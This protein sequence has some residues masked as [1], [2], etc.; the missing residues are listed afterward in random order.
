[1]DTDYTRWLGRLHD[2]AAGDRTIFCLP[3]GGGGTST[4]HGWRRA[5]PGWLDVAPVRLPGREQRLAEPAGFRPADIAAAIAA[6]ADCPYAIFGHS[7]GALVGFEVIRELRRLGAPYPLHF[8]VAAA[9]PPDVPDPVAAAVDFGDEEFIAALI[10]LIGAP[11]ALRDEPELRELALPAL[12]SDLRWLHDYAC[13]PEP[14]L[15]VPLTA[16]AGTADALFGPAV[17]L[18]WGRFTSSAFRLETVP[19]GHFFPQTAAAQVI[20]VIAADL[21]AA[22]AQAT[23]SPR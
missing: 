14:A 16:L 13:R 21:V 23:G 5:A 11:A 15:P 18:G 8:Y 19:G 12:R 22:G 7:L 20:D 17:M 10:E 3:H 6:R 1:M 9:T 2:R 4:F